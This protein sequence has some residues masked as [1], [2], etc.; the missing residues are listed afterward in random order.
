MKRAHSNFGI[1]AGIALSATFASAQA[2]SE[3]SR[4]ALRSEDRGRLTAA[5]A[6]YE[7]RAAA[8]GVEDLRALAQAMRDVRVQ[9][10]AAPE[11][12][13]ALR[14]LAQEHPNQTLG[15]QARARAAELEE[16]RRLVQ[17]RRVSEELR[18]QGAGG[19][20]QWVAVARRSVELNLGRGLSNAEVIDATVLDLGQVFNTRAQL[21]IHLGEYQRTI[22][23]LPGH[24]PL[25][26][27]LLADLERRPDVG[28]AG[29]G[30]DREDTDFRAELHDGTSNQVF[31]SNFFLVLGYA[32]GKKDPRWAHNVNLFHETL[33]RHGGTSVPDWRASAVGIEVGRGL[34]EL[35]EAGGDPRR[36]PAILGAAFSREPERYTHPWGSE[37]PDYTQLVDQ[38]QAESRERARHPRGPS[39]AG[40]AVSRVQEGLIRGLN[41]VYGDGGTQ[42]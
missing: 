18:A 12:H 21:R 11:L 39:L 38:V 4:E 42:R 15:R 40:R 22:H 2:V 13:A 8:L 14:A 29:Y 32:V 26:D 27:E 7:A 35:R 3:A 20:D 17:L 9:R 10:E 6:E 1:V 16:Q 31:H 23:R 36:I 33:E 34:R 25:L 24:D 37:G 28:F 30:I 19:V 5:L 41:G